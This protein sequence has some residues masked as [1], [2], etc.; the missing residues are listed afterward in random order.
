M[1]EEAGRRAKAQPD[2]GTGSYFALP[3][4]SAS[5]PFISA[6]GLGGQP[7]MTRSTD[8]TLATPFATA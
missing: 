2:G 5:S 8:R 7:G 1:I 6:A 4:I 3:S